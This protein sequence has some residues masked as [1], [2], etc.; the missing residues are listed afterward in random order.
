MG[1]VNLDY[2]KCDHFSSRNFD[3]DSENGV[4][5]LVAIVVWEILQFKY[6]KHLTNYKYIKMRY[7]K[8]YML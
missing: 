4:V 8:N 6:W 7:L 2:S 3:G 5:F 1:G